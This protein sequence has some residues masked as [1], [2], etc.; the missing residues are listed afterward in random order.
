MADASAFTL[1]VDWDHLIDAERHSSA[2][3]GAGG[4]MNLEKPSCPRR[5]LQRLVRRS[6]LPDNEAYRT[7][8]VSWRLMPSMSTSA[9]RSANLPSTNRQRSRTSKR[10]D[11]PV[12]GMPNISPV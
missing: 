6:P 2:A 4:T 11:R 5:L 9:R 3:A 8:S 12:A 1:L 10:M 7:G